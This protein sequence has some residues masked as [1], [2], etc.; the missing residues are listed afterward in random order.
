MLH[1]EHIPLMLP[2]NNN[3]NLTHLEL[4]NN[5]LMGAA[6]PYLRELILQSSSLKSIS[7][8]LNRQLPFED[9]RSLAELRAQKPGLDIS[10]D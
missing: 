6:T 3:K 10:I 9:R 5:S 7:L 2:L 1:D 4:S 8:F